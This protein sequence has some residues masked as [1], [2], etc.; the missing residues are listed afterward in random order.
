MSTTQTSDVSAK[1]IG[2]REIHPGL[3]L[4]ILSTASFLAALDVWIT[5]VGLPAIGEGVHTSSFSDLSWVLNG[6]AIVYAALL[7]P[8]GRIA[9]R[10]GRK[11]AFLTGMTI[12]AIASLGAGLSSDTWVLVGFRVLQ[13]V[14]AAVLTPASLGLVLTTAPPEKVSAYVKV[15]FTTGALAAAVGPVAGGLLIEA[16]WRWLFLV[17]LPVI[18]VAFALAAVYVPAVRH[19]QETALP[20]LLG[21]FVLVVSVG[22]LAFGLVKS[23]DYGWDSAEVVGSFVIAAVALVAF[24]ARSQ[25]HEAPIVQLSLFRSRVFTSANLTTVMVSASFSVVLLSVIL[26][27]QG[28]WD[29]SA[30]RTGLATAPIPVMFITFAVAAETLQSKTR[31]RPAAIA[32]V[33]LAVTAIGI[34]LMASA[35]GEDPEYLRELFGPLILIGAGFGA[36][37]PIA[38]SSATVDLPPKDSA[39]GSAV[40]S[41]SQQ[42]GSVVGVSV[43]VALLGAASQAAI[44]D[45]FRNAWIAAVVIAALGAASGLGLN[46]HKSNSA[47]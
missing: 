43:L 22:A 32:G 4:A 38:I 8:G 31:I 29:Y 19:D 47:G 18:I 16:S 23:T 41:M 2:H 28:H 34:L 15:W 46:A 17:N 33:G 39:T 3:V 9:D 44:R 5:N 7:V 30:I 40:V 27:L 11:G 6:Y 10:F 45:D 14:G 24:I 12:F 13:A 25:R 37:L 35:L 20:D 21:G 42:M 1:P 36:S 26:W